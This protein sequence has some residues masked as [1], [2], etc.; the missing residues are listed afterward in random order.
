MLHLPLS[1][2]DHLVLH[3]KITILA[4]SL[5]KDLGSGQTGPFNSYKENEVL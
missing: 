4:P 2:F 3:V 1:Y 5:V